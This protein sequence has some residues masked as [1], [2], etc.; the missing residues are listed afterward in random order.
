MVVVGR[1]VRADW[2]NDQRVRPTTSDKG[3]AR[4]Y[5]QSARSAWITST[6]AARIAGHAEATTA[7]SSRI[8]VA[9]TTTQGPGIFKL[10]K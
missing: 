8:P 4:P 2:N 5:H 7:A 1:A 3:R 9:P 6:R 10:S